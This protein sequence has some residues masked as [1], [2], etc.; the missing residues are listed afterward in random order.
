VKR[1]LDIS[2]AVFGLAVGS[3]V[4]VPTMFLVWMQD[5]HS[6]FYI[7][8]R[9]ARGGGT[10]RMVKLRS[11]KILADTTGVMS[12]AGDDPRITAVGRFI[13]KAKLD[14]LTQLWNVLKGDM[15]LVGPR[16]QVEPDARLYTDVERDMLTVR[17]G[18]TD[19]ASIVFSDEGE[20]LRGAAD[21]DARY[22]AV[23]RPW[24]SRLALLYV[25]NN[26]GVVLDLRI[27]ALTLLGAVDRTQALASVSRVV[28]TLGGDDVLCQ[29]A[30]RARPLTEEPPPG[31]DG[32]ALHFVRAG[33]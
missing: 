2:A 27:V 17:P 28:A 24:K 33:R 12:T 22:N 31:R 14:E 26:T 3:V 10:F 29:V 15:S 32:A 21:P 9:V 16:P 5:R 4:L 30:A 11:M 20:I 19:L 8:T 25:Y 6:P 7:A 18:I 23:I 1:I 13:R